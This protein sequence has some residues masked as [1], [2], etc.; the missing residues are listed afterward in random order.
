MATASSVY[1]DDV[2]YAHRK[3]FLGVLPRDTGNV[4]CAAMH[5]PTEV[6]AAASMSSYWP[7]HGHDCPTIDAL[8]SLPVPVDVPTPSEANGAPLPVQTV[9][10]APDI[11]TTILTA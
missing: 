6:V 4:L 2:T 7:V 8:S 1:S 5:I 10:A 9:L 11:A 3:V